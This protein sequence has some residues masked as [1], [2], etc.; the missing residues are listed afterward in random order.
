VIGLYEVPQTLVIEPASYR[1]FH[2]FL[3]DKGTE[4]PFAGI[5]E[6]PSLSKRPAR[7]IIAAVSGHVVSMS[8][9]RRK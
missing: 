5:E 3:S 4:L 8:Y 2:D 6:S 1:K 7:P 9:L